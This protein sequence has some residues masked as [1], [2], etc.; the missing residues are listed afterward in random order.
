[1]GGKSEILIILIQSTHFLAVSSIFLISS[2]SSGGCKW[3][4]TNW[5]LLVDRR[6]QHFGNWDYHLLWS[7]NKKYTENAC[8][9]HTS[10]HK[11]AFWFEEKT[12]QLIDDLIVKDN[13][14]TSNYE[15]GRVFK[16]MEDTFHISYPQTSKDINVVWWYK[17]GRGCC[18]VYFVWK[19]PWA[20]ALLVFA[21]LLRE[22]TWPHSSWLLKKSCSV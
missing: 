2:S 20:P 6:A 19:L 4:L 21:W 10:S 16:S 1:M 3:T 9:E 11:R 17:V 7:R 14:G 22:T 15:G 12:V 5:E 18:F 8:W 13:I